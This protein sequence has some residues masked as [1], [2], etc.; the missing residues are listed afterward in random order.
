MSPCPVYLRRA[1]SPATSVRRVLPVIPFQPS[2]R[3][4]VSVFRALE[5]RAAPHS[6]PLAGA[7]GHGERL[8]GSATTEPAARGIHR[9]ADICPVDVTAAIGHKDPLDT[10]VPT[11]TL[12][13]STRKERGLAHGQSW[14]TA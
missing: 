3:H 13:S 9:G 8:L 2:T 5:K 4:R 6:L 7:T 14:L 10:L 12:H 11:A 1:F